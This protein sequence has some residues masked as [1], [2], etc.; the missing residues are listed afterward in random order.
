MTTRI[1]TR[2]HV[3]DAAEATLSQHTTYTAALYAVAAL[4]A[5]AEREGSVATYDIWDSRT[6]GVVNPPA[7]PDD[8][9][10]DITLPVTP[11]ERAALRRVAE[12]VGA[13]AP[14]GRWVAQPS[15]AGL[16]RG[17]ASGELVVQRGE[18]AGA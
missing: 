8:D 9:A 5:R 15:I 3:R 4:R 6:K 10:P 2:Y 16:V 14:R 18:D 11:D 17:I 13:L 12:S 7:A 1:R